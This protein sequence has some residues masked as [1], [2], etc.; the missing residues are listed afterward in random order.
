MNRLIKKC[1]MVWLIGFVC[2][3]GV[4]AQ[5]SQN[6]SPAQRRAKE[7]ARLLDSGNRAEL[8][9][10]AKENFAPRFLNVPM[11]QHLAWS[12]TLYRR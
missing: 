12:F 9:K 4:Q 1:V 8:V 11:E 7:F 3:L 5:S 10:Y 6:E 2:V